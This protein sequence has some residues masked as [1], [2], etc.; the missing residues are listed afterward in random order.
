MSSSFNYY[1]YLISG[2]IH[3]ILIKS[4]LNDFPAV[5]FRDDTPGCNQVLHFNNAGSS[6]TT[7]Q[8]LNAVIDH[9]RS[10]SLIGGYEAAFL[11]QERLSQVYTSAALLL[12]CTSEEIAIT[13]SATNAWDMA[14]Y[15]MRFKPGDK[16]LTSETEYVSNYIALRQQAM[17][18]GAIVDIVPNDENKQIS[19]SALNERID[20]KVKLIA[21]THVP[22]NSGIVSPAEQV[23]RIAND[24]GIV[25]L[26]DACQSVG[27][28]PIDVKA[29]GCDILSATG[30]KYLRAPRGTG[31]LYVRKALLKQLDPPFLDTHSAV[32]NPR[33]NIPR[34]RNDAKKFESWESNIAAKLGLGVALDYTLNVGLLDSYMYIRTIAQLLRDTISSIK[35][36]SVE[37]SATEQCGLV[38]FAVRGLPVGEV[39]EKLRSQGINLSVSGP[40]ML[41]ASVHYYNTLAE[42]YRF[43][44][45]LEKII[46]NG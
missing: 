43:A 27:Q 33:T 14:F 20:K 26:L 19:L 37:L 36:V 6:L 41:R 35:K 25:Y 12:N 42:V 3:F 8:S 34:I 7:S 30:R 31:I 29:I 44:G 2:L 4:I 45:A 28:M 40:D 22:S 10:E 9:L 24:A 18:Y 23:G 11:A 46:D 5:K 32:L 39:H 38:M 17:R 16:I 13:E 1:I 15:S 21:L